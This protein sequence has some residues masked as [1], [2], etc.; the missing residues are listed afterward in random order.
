MTSESFT[1]RLLAGERILWS[2]QPQ[3][4]LL[5]TARDIFAIPFSLAWCGFAVFWTVM[6]TGAS[7][8]DANPAGGFFILWGLMFVVIGLYFVF[9]RFIVDA[10]VR[11][12]LNYAVTD[13]RILI[14]RGA[15]FGR[16]TALSLARLPDIDLKERG[17]ARGT[18]RFGQP[19]AIWGNRG[20]SAWSVALDPTPQFLGIEDARRVFDLIQRTQAG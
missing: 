7:A 19:V 5:L 16:F 9:G 4:G 13:Q 10:W 15:P 12:G 14:A 8:S 3:Q 2:G 18:I 20:M 17:N 11:R 1:G 6:V